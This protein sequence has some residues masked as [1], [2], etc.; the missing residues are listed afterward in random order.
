MSMKLRFTCLNEN[1]QA[2]CYQSSGASGMDLHACLQESI[3]LEPQQVVLVPTGLAFEIPQGYEG[4]VRP[5]SGLA[6]KHQIVVVNSPGTI[7]A[8]YRGEVKIILGNWGKEAF[9]IEHGDRIAQFV[10]CP[11][12]QVELEQAVS[13]SETSRG[14]GGFGST[15]KADAS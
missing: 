4:Q 1:A 12:V 15:G 11:I 7:D 6:L 13:L 10:V 2:P 8:D 14:A 5:R 9:T 3:T